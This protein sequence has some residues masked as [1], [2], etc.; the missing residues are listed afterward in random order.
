M[1]DYA[2]LKRFGKAEEIAELLAFASKQSRYLAGVEHPCAT[3][4]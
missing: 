4:E 2:A 1:V 3:V